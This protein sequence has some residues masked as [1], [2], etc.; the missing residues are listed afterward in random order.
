MVH[1]LLGVACGAYN[2]SAA[3]VDIIA[4]EVFESIKYFLVPNR[5]ELKKVDWGGG[6]GIRVKI[7]IKFSRILNF[8]ESTFMFNSYPPIF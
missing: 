4:A 2:T 6:V 8:S 3:F 1:R 5:T 7:F